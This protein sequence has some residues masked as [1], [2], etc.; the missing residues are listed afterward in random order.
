[1]RYC[2]VCTHKD[3]PAK[4]SLAIK[5]AIED[6]LDEEGILDEEVAVTEIDCFSLCVYAPNV[7]VMPDRIVFSHVKLTDV[8]RIVDFLKGGPRPGDLEIGPKQSAK[9]VALER[10]ALMLEEY[11]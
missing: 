1:M 10:C 11:V 8:E 9:R 6:R 2:V 3:C 5:R 7:A 4:G